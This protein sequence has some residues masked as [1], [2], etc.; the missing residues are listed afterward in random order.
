MVW[1]VFSAFT[2]FTFVAYFTPATQLAG[3]VAAFN[4]GPWETFW[5]IFYG[6]AT[7]GNAG[8]MREQVCLYMCPYARFQ[9]AMFDD[10]TLVVSYDEK[11]GEPR[12]PRRVGTDYRARGL[13]DC[14]NCTLCVQVCPTGIDIRDGLQYQCIS[15]SACIDACNDVMDKMGYSRGLIRYTTQNAVQGKKTHVLRPR[16][17]IYGLIMLTFIGAFSY[18]V[19]SRV[20]L[21][22]DVI[23]DR[24]Q[25]YRET[26]D[27]IE[28][29]YTLKVLNMDN[30]PHQYRISINGEGIEHMRLIADQNPVS[31]N[32]GTV[33]DVPV[34]VRVDEEHLEHRSSRIRFIITDLHNPDLEVT[35]GARFLGPMP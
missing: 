5:M 9:S 31:V 35:E 4:L 12:G 7:Y 10:D 13:G 8:W 17:I 27:Q 21:Q 14:I 28:N 6:F 18:L 19:A 30:H 20:P 33:L 2:G 16:I 32:A 15:C 29:V 23:R 11:R 22:L 34:R 3:K 25:L 24:N 1:I 26:G